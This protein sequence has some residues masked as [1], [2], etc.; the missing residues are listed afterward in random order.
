MGFDLA[1]SIKSEG[2]S[3]NPCAEDLY[4]IALFWWQSIK[5]PTLRSQPLALFHLCIFSAF[6]LLRHLVSERKRLFPGMILF[7]VMVFL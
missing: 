6:P 3:C 1:A 7:E 5:P 4:G 2:I